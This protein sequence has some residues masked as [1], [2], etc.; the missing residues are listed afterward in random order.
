MTCLFI[1]I[2]LLSLLNID[3]F[4]CL[5]VAT[6]ANRC[7]PLC[8]RCTL[9]STSSFSRVG[10]ARASPLRARVYCSKVRFNVT[11]V[12]CTL[13]IVLNLQLYATYFTVFHALCNSSAL[14]WGTAWPLAPSERLRRSLARICDGCT[15]GV[16][17]LRRW[18]S[19]GTASTSGRSGGGS[20]A[21]S[22]ERLSGP[23]VYSH[24]S[25]R[26]TN[27]SDSNCQ[28]WILPMQIMYTTFIGF[29]CSSCWG[30][31]SKI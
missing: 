10:F 4:T 22:R 18:R 1:V 5:G 28:A 23:N 24:E 12:Y 17:W 14:W 15:V 6:R 9:R 3:K 7:G 19:A 26:L 16:R 13:C 31:L 8:A 21:Q 11:D 30:L 25:C 20:A 2:D 29:V 27:L